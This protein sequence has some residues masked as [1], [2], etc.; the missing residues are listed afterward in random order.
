[1]TARAY[2]LPQAESDPRFTFGLQLDVADVLEKHGFP[3]VSGV[4]LVDLGQALFRFLYASE[5][6]PVPTPVEDASPLTLA[7]YQSALAY[8]EQKATEAQAAGDQAAIAYRTSGVES[9]RKTVR[10]LAAE[11]GAQ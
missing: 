2:P 5:E 3:R 9:L 8:W 7:E 11:G 10:R 1:M 4:D 6:R